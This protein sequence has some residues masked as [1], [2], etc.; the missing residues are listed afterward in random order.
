MQQHVDPPKLVKP[1]SAYFD[2]PALIT[3]SYIAV[4]PKA[5]RER[6]V[7]VAQVLAQ[8]DGYDVHATASLRLMQAFGLRFKEACML[9]PHA[10]VLT[11][12]QAGQSD[13]ASRRKTWV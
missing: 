10:D 12:A 3:R 7:D 2:D 1:L 13:L 4:E 11:A 6:G 9:R 8:I 5:R